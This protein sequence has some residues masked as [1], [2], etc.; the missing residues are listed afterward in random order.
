MFYKRHSGRIFKITNPP[1]FGHSWYLNDYVR[2][3]LRC[4]LLF[5]DDI[6]LE[7][8]VQTT[9]G[10]SLV[11]SQPFIIGRN[12][13]EEEIAEWFALKGCKKLGPNKWKYPH[14]SIVS[15]AHPGNFVLYTSKGNE[16]DRQSKGT[17]LLFP[18][19]LHVDRLEPADIG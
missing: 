4:N 7:G 1:H 18:I 3:A 16:A 5:E 9:E 8:V 17:P 12:P 19:D 10:V 14:G 6:Q 2:N 13:S 11:I 15:D